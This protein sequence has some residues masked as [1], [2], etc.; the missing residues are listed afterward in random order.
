MSKQESL[1]TALAS[2]KA[3]T[4]KSN[5]LVIDAKAGND[6]IVGGSAAQ[7]LYGGSGNDIIQGV[8]GDDV[9][10]GDG[11]S[12]GATF[13]AGRD[14]FVFE[15]TLAANGVD[16]VMDFGIAG[17]K[18]AGVLQAGTYVAD[19]LD[20]SRVKFTGLPS[21]GE[22]D[23]GECEGEQDDDGEEVHITA[24]NVN[25]YVS[26]KGGDLYIDTD[27]LG[28]G[29]AEVWAH[30]EGVAGGDLVNLKFDDF[31]GQ[32]E[33]KPGFDFKL[34][35]ALNS[36]DG[37]TLVLFDGDYSIDRS[38]VTP[39]ELIEGKADTSTIKTILSHLDI[40]VL[41]SATVAN[42]GGTQW[43]ING[44]KALGTVDVLTW[45]LESTATSLLK[46]YNSIF[47]DNSLDLNSD[48]FINYAD[49]VIADA[50]FGMFG[51]VIAEITSTLPVLQTQYAGQVLVYFND[52]AFAAGETVTL[53]GSYQGSEVFQTVLAT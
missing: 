19:T 48:G 4:I 27:G 7:T 50:D 12:T 28:A 10:W 38:G 25:D 33:A 37:S 46:T 17:H 6:R 8:G 5:A 44:Q 21:T 29:K 9:L 52:A 51:G 41:D 42:L 23:E 13:V 45:T 47:G 15:K 53:V 3:D 20:L 16:T 26:V 35:K 32:I 24:A 43:S 2:I 31:L 30:L 36:T 40:V 34:L 1:R 39:V 14:T 22:H 49:V 11:S 18:T